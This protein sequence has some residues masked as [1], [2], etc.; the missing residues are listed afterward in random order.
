MTDAEGLEVLITGIIGLE[1]KSGQMVSCTDGSQD[2]ATFT[3][4]S[5]NNLFEALER[6][7]AIPTRSR[8]GYSTLKR[9]HA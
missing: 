8:R 6:V 7:T 9:F 3:Q 5:V 4:Q 1:W 2:R